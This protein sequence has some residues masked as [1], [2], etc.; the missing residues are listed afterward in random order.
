MLCL[1]RPECFGYALQDTSGTPLYML[2]PIN[3][4][5]HVSP[6]F[7]P[8]LRLDAPLSPILHCV[9]PGHRTVTPSAA[10]VID[11]QPVEQSSV[12]LPIPA[13]PEDISAAQALSLVSGGSNQRIIRGTQRR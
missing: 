13:S 6:D 12:A 1:Q 4:R 2:D 9:L 7:G 11:A 10:A 3:F 8:P 5:E